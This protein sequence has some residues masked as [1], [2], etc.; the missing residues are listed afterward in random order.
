MYGLI[1]IMTIPR[2]TTSKNIDK[3]CFYFWRRLKNANCYEY[4]VCQFRYLF[5]DNEGLGFL[6]LADTVLIFINPSPSNVNKLLHPMFF[7]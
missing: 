7:S 1:V 4:N 3:I 6:K 5:N 2:R